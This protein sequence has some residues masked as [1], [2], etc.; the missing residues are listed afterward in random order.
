MPY[1]TNTFSLADMTGQVPKYHIPCRFVTIIPREF[2]ASQPP[3]A[4]GKK[5][6]SSTMG[7]PTA[8]KNQKAQD[9]FLSMEFDGLGSFDA[10]DLDFDKPLGVDEEG[11]DFPP[12]L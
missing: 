7:A 10:L 12:M 3:S 4:A 11:D 5:R 2:P 9:D 6:K 1:L 8:N